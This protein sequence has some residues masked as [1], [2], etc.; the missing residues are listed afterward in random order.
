[1]RF[2]L[3]T[4]G[5]RGDVQPLVALGAELVRRGHTVELAAP[6]SAMPLA[7]RV[8][9]RAVALPGDWQRFLRSAETDKSWV[10]SGDGGVQMAAIRDIM[11]DYTAELAAT[12]CGFSQGA[13]VIV[14]GGLTEDVAAVIAEAYRV[15]LALV[16]MY[17]VRPTG[18][19]ANPIM[20]P[21]SFER[22]EQNRQTHVQYK[23]QVWAARRDG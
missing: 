1:M 19:V 13:D 6:E 22:P 5:T 11:A 23:Q 20:A 17:P 2:A 15:P 12:L 3:M 4:H 21:R 16:H 10:F 9:V 8:G 14:S 7:D 18:A